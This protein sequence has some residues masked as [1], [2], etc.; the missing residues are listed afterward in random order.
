[1]VNRFAALVVLAFVALLL[2]ACV[3]PGRML[4]SGV[5]IAP[6]AL[7]LQG[8][9]LT[10][11]LGERWWQSFADPQLDTLVAKALQ[12]H[13]SLQAAAARVARAQALMERAE[14]QRLPQV[15]ARLDISHQRFSENG[16]FPPTVAGKVKDTGNL[17][18]S[19]AWELD[20]FG[21]NRAAFEGALGAERAAQAD[22]YSARLTLAAGVVRTY[23]QLAQLLAERAVAERTLAQRTQVLD[24]IRRRVQAGIDTNVELRQGEG[25]LPDIRLA[26]EIL[27]EQITLRHHALAA[28]TVQ[29]PDALAMLTPPIATLQRVPLPAELPADLLGRRPDIDAARLRIEA[30][31]SD[32]QGARADFYPSVNLLAFAGFNAIGLGNLLDFGSRQAGIGPAVRL[33]LFDAGRL[34]ANYRGKAADLDAAIAAYNG[35]VVEAVREAA[36][37]IS[38]LLSIERQQAEQARAQASVESAYE[39]AVARYKAGLGSYLVV[40]SA[41]SA[42]LTQRRASVDLKARTLVAQAELMRALGGGYVAMPRATSRADDKDPRL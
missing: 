17:Q 23:I 28:L 10:P 35:A 14:A 29:P 8:D 26:I 19:F 4:P 30:A 7:G 34:R 11:D 2:V 25:A 3:G 39:L 18:A 31:T 37:Q 40:L 15:D 27:D 5:R 16:L 22:R 1:M 20:F 38:S 24:L 9:T 41:E 13:P 32:L 42:V 21:R 12:D 33:P 36:D 6:A